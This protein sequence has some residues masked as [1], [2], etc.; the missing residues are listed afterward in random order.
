ML[1][2][3]Y[4]PLNTSQ[5]QIRG[6]IFDCGSVLWHSTKPLRSLQE[7]ALRRAVQSL[8]RLSDSDASS[9]L[10]AFLRLRRTFNARK[11]WIGTGT[12]LDEG[13][14]LQYPVHKLVRD[15][16]A[17][18]D[19]HRVTPSDMEQLC[20]AYRQPALANAQLMDGARTFLEWCRRRRLRCAVCSNC[21]DAQRT[22]A[23]LCRFGIRRFFDVVAISGDA[24]CRLF[25]KPDVRILAPILERWRDLRR[26]QMVFIGDNPRRDALL[27]HFAN[28]SSIVCR[29]APNAR[30]ETEL[31]RNCKARVASESGGF[32]EM[33]GRDLSVECVA[34]ELGHTRSERTVTA[35]AQIPAALRSMGAIPASSRRRALRVAFLMLPHQL[36]KYAKCRLFAPRHSRDVECV[37][38]VGRLARAAIICRQADQQ[39]AMIL[40]RCGDKLL[41]FLGMNMF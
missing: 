24:R 26:D 41:F 30:D 40:I 19:R 17:A 11:A 14:V 5:T 37:E 15:A 36:A 25:R 12:C 18:I 29:F 1:I 2:L 23:L 27:A 8:L 13:F 21:C 31:R 6:L 35:F 38:V 39:V 7:A 3:W 4:K 32:V 28:L 22:K 20:A 33:S 34:D 10:S 16:L 9:F